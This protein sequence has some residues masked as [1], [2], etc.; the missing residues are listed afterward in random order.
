MGIGLRFDEMIQVALM[1]H[2]FFLPNTDGLHLE[3]TLILKA[4][5]GVG[6]NLVFE[7][8][9]HLKGVMD[10]FSWPIT[11]MKTCSKRVDAIYVW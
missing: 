8:K 1:W 9:V 3:N 4:I 7:S 5:Y 2:H 10:P 11:L 6:V